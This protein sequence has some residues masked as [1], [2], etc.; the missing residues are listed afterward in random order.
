MEEFEINIAGSKSFSNRAIILAAQAN[1]LT[2][3]KNISK[4]DDTQVLIRALE[5]FGVEFLESESAGENDLLVKAPEEYTPY[6]GVIDIGPAGTSMRF[7]TAFIAGID[8]A[9]AEIRG[10]ERMHERPV[11]DLVDA[12]VS[13]GVKVDYAGQTGC[14]PIKVYGRQK[15]ARYSFNVNADISSQYLSALLLSAPLLASYVEIIADSEIV[16]Y[17][18]VDM[19]I[20]TMKKFGIDV[21]TEDK[22][23]FLVAHSQPQAGEYLI[24]ADATGAGYFMALAA[25][26][27]KKIRIN[28]LSSD[29]PQGD[30]ALLSI[31]QQAGVEVTKGSN[32]VEFKGTDGLQAINADLSLLPDSGQTLAV[33]AAMIKGKSYLTG[34]GTLKHKEC[35]RLQATHDELLKLG[36]KTEITDDSITVYGGDIQVPAGGVEIATYDDHRM[37]MS[38]AILA[39]KYQGIKILSPEVVNKSFPDFWEKLAECGVAC[40]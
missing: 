12:L 38:F 21:H 33:L 32:W 28:N 23:Y 34:L 20:A 25:V 35:D 39:S 6:Q 27:G 36:I 8:G 5:K 18:Y 30:M 10:S 14:P 15:Q 37:A 4:S 1:G 17:S 2:R 19:T 40:S 16:S 29:S 31:L 13:Q 9:I 7:M 11:K 26:S 3:L 22:K 24:D